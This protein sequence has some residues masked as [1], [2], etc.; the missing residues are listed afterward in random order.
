MLPLSFEKKYDNLEPING[1]NQNQRNDRN[2]R[3]IISRGKVDKVA[4]VK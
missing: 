1:T 2:I 4:N 3:Q